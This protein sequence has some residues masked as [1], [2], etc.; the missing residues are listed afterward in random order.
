MVRMRAW[1]PLRALRYGGCQQTSGQIVIY[2][3]RTK[4]RVG[5]TQLALAQRTTPAARDSC[6]WKRVVTVRPTKV[7]G[8]AP[9]IAGQVSPWCGRGTPACKSTKSEAPRKLL[10]PPRGAPTF[11]LSSQDPKVSEAALHVFDAQRKLAGHPG[12]FGQGRPLH[13]TVDKKLIAKNRG[14]ACPKR[15]PRPP[16]K[17]CDEFPFASTKEGGASGTYS[18]RMINAKHTSDAGGSNYLLKAYRDHR[19]LNGDAFWVNGT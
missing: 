1:G 17:S 6:T 4:K 3:T 9:G 8:A 7:T 19:I 18:R 13:R 11:T 12:L 16:G 15:L 2:E 14:A 5:L 10:H